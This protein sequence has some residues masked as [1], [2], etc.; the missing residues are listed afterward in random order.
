[1][2]IAGGLDTEKVSESFGSHP[3]VSQLTGGLRKYSIVWR[4]MGIAFSRVSL[5]TSRD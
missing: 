4:L 5:L 3:R 2:T 1:M